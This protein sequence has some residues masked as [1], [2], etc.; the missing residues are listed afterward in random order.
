MTI[1]DVV[2]RAHKDHLQKVDDALKVQVDI[3]LDIIDKTLANLAQNEPWTNQATFRIG[4]V[5]KPNMDEKFL[6][7]QVPDV[8]IAELVRQHYSNMGFN[9]GVTKSANIFDVNI[10]VVLEWS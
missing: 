6:K 10:T 2:K 3:W 5:V 4:K 7:D 8:K 9:I 1:L